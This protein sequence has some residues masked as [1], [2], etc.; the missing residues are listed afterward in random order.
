MP[1][2]TLL[3]PLVRPATCAANIT[4]AAG[5]PH[6]HAPSSS[7]AANDAP[8][9]LAGPAPA[10]T[11]STAVLEVPARSLAGCAADV[12]RT[13]SSLAYTATSITA[14]AIRHGAV[15]AGNAPSKSPQASSTVPVQGLPATV[16]AVVA[17]GGTATASSS[18]EAKREAQRRSWASILTAEQV[19][20]LLW[21]GASEQGW[22][23]DAGGRH[24]HSPQGELFRSYGSLPNTKAGTGGGNRTRATQL[25]LAREAQTRLLRSLA[26]K[27]IEIWWEFDEKWY[28]CKV[29]QVLEE[30]EEEEEDLAQ[31]DGGGHRQSAISNE[32]SLLH[33]VVYTLD[34]ENETIDLSPGKN[35]WRP[36]D[37]PEGQKEMQDEL[38]RRH[39]IGAFAGVKVRSRSAKRRPAN[40]RV[41]FRL[42]YPA[43]SP[44]PSAAAAS[45]LS[46]RSKVPGPK[47]PMGST[48][49]R[50][51]ATDMLRS[52]EAGGGDG[53]GRDVGITRGKG[54]ALTDHDAVEEE[55]VESA[56][57]LISYKQCEKLLQQIMA[58]SDAAPFLQPVDHIRDGLVDY[59]SVVEFPM[60]LGTVR[61]KVVAKSYRHPGEFVDDV[62]LVW[63]NAMKY[64]PD[65]HPIHYAANGLRRLFERRLLALVRPNT[66]PSVTIPLQPRNAEGGDELTRG[67]EERHT[68]QDLPSGDGGCAASTEA[69]LGGAEDEDMPDFAGTTSNVDVADE[70]QSADGDA[71]LAAE[72][73]GSAHEMS[74][75]PAMKTSDVYA[76]D[77]A[78]ARPQYGNADMPGGEGVPTLPEEAATRLS[79]MGGA[80]SLDSLDNDA[81]DNC[82]L[83]DLN[84]SDDDDDAE[85]FT[86]DASFGIVGV[87]TLPVM[88]PPAAVC[89]PERHLDDVG[90]ACGIANAIWPH[91]SQ[92]MS[93]NTGQHTS[94]A[95]ALGALE[96]EADGLS[97]DVEDEDE[98][99]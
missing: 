54:L 19:D 61:E 45:I 20:A 37:T 83:H 70:L 25:A 35:V 24:V 56:S 5:R 32:G 74:E 1:G 88:D 29:M 28:T 93:Q 94:Q 30:E 60:D 55:P 81:H 47:T 73:P 42:H 92:H 31:R 7:S 16:P 2:V 90:N 40:L 38:D 27:F 79:S 68:T 99:S 96:A 95:A 6:G 69:H 76:A 48:T 77:T 57:L 17:L 97:D 3:H 63:A 18:S 66:T 15:V 91:T 39:G 67:L 49:L 86:Y 9:V 23:A 22:R 71:E 8:I 26:G 10:R 50:T 52:A 82:C 53:E 98:G 84:S 21:K 62:R 41:L 58:I 34:N 89:K 80:S 51:P 11:A 44:S 78:E 43:G 85:D 72:E 14:S 87:E 36:C 59:M 4:A 75:Q 33:L 46:K 64:N 13:D 65:H 12:N